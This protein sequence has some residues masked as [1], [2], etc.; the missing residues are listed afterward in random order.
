MV[1]AISPDALQHE[2]LTADA[3]SLAGWLQTH[4]GQKL[5]GFSVGLNDVK[6]VGRYAKGTVQPRDLVLWRMQAAYQAARLIS[7]E[8]GDVAAKSWFFGSNSVLEDRAPAMVLRTAVTPDGISQ[9]VPAAR[10]FVSGGFS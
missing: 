3:A 2:A 5:A 9:V 7:D 8:F 1:T 4:L 6:Q 10:S